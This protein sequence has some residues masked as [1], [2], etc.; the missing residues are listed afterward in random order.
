ML[1]YLV[2][3]AVLAQGASSP[4]ALARE[5]EEDLKAGKPSVACEKLENAIR[6]SPL[7]PALWFLLGLG[8]ARLKQL[9]RAVEA[10]DKS[11]A[12]D[13]RYAPAYF[14]LG[15]LYGYKGQAEKALEMYRRGLKIDP[16]D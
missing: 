10:F 15:L 6:A 2:L 7:S 12:I 11:I 9:D 5:A 14:N 16:N 4:A 8:R 1:A 3:I 13:P